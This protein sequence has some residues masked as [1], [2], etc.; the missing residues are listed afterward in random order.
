LTD[1]FVGKFLTFNSLTPHAPAANPTLRAH[2][3]GFT[4]RSCGPDEKHVL[5]RQ[6]DA[7]A[8]IRREMQQR[9]RM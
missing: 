9:E 4:A 7:A 8:V 5:E 3:Q 1:S 6:H 2:P